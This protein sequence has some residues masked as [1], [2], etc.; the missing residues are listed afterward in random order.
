M[1]HLKIPHWLFR[2]MLW[3]QKINNPPSAGKILGVT[4]SHVSPWNRRR[5]SGQLF[6]WPWGFVHAVWHS[7]ARLFP[8]QGWSTR[9]AHGWEQ[10]CILCAFMCVCGGGMILVLCVCSKQLHVHPFMWKFLS[11]AGSWNDLTLFPD[12]LTSPRQRKSSTTWKQRIW[13]SSWRTTERRDTPGPSPRPLWRR[14]TLLATSPAPHSWPRLLTPSLRGASLVL[15]SVG[16][17]FWVAPH[18]CW[19]WWWK[20][21]IEKCVDT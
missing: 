4:P 13:A 16:F 7:R 5:D 1:R 6:V 15:S 20:Q 11:M 2:W 17:G 8:Q 14:V 10:V 18:C 21:K 12:V 9:Y 19:C 3:F